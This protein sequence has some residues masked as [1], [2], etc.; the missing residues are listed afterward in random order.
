MKTALLILVLYALAGSIDFEAAQT[1]QHIVVER[2][3]QVA[4]SSH[5]KHAK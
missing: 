4:A 2:D 5:L 1:T 3:A